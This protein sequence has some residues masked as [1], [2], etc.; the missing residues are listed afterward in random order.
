M[1]KLISYLFHPLFAPIYSLALI[2]NL[3]IY[4]NFKYGDEYFL[5]VYFLLFVNLVLAPLFVS[6]YLR[7]VGM[8]E[9]L[10]M[11]DVK[12]RVLPY[13]TYVIFFVFTYFLLFKLS[14]PPI[15]LNLYAMAGISIFILVILALVKFKI[16]AHMVAMG[17]V[18]GMLLVLAHHFAMD[19]S[20][21]MMAVIL[22][23]AMVASARLYLSAHSPLEVF[24]GF[25]LGM[26]SQMIL[27]LF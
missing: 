19:L 4:L 6:L 7:R 8:I 24:L 10:E 26:G 23:T 21:W 17:G 20:W 14:F 13:L 22:A 12:E 11:R 16:S 5:Y 2:T 3:P 25:C 15:Y 1:A 27:L 18:C 9:S